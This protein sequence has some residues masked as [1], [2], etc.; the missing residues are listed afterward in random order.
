MD[1][2]T[3][4][5]TVRRVPR[6]RITLP[7]LGLVAVALGIGPAFNDATHP[8]EGAILGLASAKGMVPAVDHPEKGTEIFQ[9]D[10]DLQDIAPFSIG[11]VVDPE[12]R[13]GGKR[14]V[15]VKRPHAPGLYLAIRQGEMRYWIRKL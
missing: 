14:Y 2:G 3:K 13:N 9:W 15:L 1:I 8:D 5:S 4:P 11:A 10:P 6:A 7:L 12:F